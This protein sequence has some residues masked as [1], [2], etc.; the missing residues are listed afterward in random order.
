M[1]RVSGTTPESRRRMLLARMAATRA[2]L[3]ASN[4]VIEMTRLTSLTANIGYAPIKL[5]AIGGS[6]GAAIAVALAAL[7]VMGPRRLVMTAV[8]AGLVGLL[9]RMVRD[10]MHR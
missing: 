3:Y 8:R 10:A 1:K 5:P 7:V 9:G 6:T 2:E 4:H